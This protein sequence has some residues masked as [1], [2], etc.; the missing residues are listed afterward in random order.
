MEEASHLSLTEL[1]DLVLDKSGLKS[2]LEKENSVEA[3]TRLENLEE[4]KSITKSFEDKYGLI[5]LPDFLYEVS[6]ISDNTEI[7]D[8]SDRVTLMTIHAVKGLEFDNVFITGLE[9]GLFPHVNSMNSNSEIE[10]ERRL[11]YVAITRARNKLYIT[12]SRSRVLYGMEQVNP[13]SRFV[14]EI[15]SNLLNVVN[16]EE[17]SFINISNAPKKVLIEEVESE[18]LPNEY[19]YHDIFG[20]GKVISV[21]KSVIK[22]AFKMPYGIKTLMKNHHSLHKINE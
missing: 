16:K 22:I 9:E 1:V 3:E 5:S 19:V 4:F 6:L 8:S 20:T 15:D 21:D 13:V 11:C 17:T 10:E 2:E 12:N 18:Y 14:Q 7:T